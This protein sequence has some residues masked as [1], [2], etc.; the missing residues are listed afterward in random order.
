VK[1]PFIRDSTVHSD[2][3]R[4]GNALREHFSPCAI[5]YSQISFQRG[6]RVFELQLKSGKYLDTP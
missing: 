5:E 4:F 1:I 2:V 3:A 6:E